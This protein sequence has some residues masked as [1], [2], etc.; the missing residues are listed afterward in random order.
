[1]RYSIV[2]ALCCL[3]VA[4]G[5]VHA[6]SDRGTITGTIT[7][8]AGAV[9]PNATIEAKNSETGAV[10]RAGSTETGN[11]TLSQLPAGVYQLSSS[12]SGFKQY[13]RTGITV[14]VAQTLRLDIVLEVGSIAETVTV[15]ADAPLLRTESGELSHNVTEARLD[16]LPILGFTGI[17]RDPYAVMTLLPGTLYQNR[18]WFRVNGAPSATMS[19]R[20]EGMEATNGM[21]AQSTGMSQQSMSAIEEYA[22][23]TSNYA[24]EFGQAGGGYF[25]ITMKSGTN[26]Y[27]GSA[28]D[29]LS[30]EAFNAAQPFVNIKTRLRRNDYGF[31]FGGPVFIP[32]VY[33]GH[34]KTFFFFN[35][36]QYR[37]H[38]LYNQTA[39]TMPTLA[40]RSGDFRQALTGRKLGTD[41]LGRDIMENTIYDPNTERLVNGQRVR[42]PFLNNT[43][44]SDRFD[45]VAVKIQNYIPLPQGPN[46]NSIT[47]N[48]L[49][50]WDS[51]NI[52]WIPGFKI[53]HNISAR[54][55]LAFFWSATHIHQVQAPGPPGGDG[56][57][58][59]ATTSRQTIQDS[60]IAHLSF[61]QTLTPTMV[62][63]LGTGL[64]NL[65]F[66]DPA[67]DTNFDQLKNLGL[68]GSMYNVFPF[69]SGLSAARGGM[70]ARS[71]GMPTGNMGPFMQT[72]SVMF[73]PAANA[74][75]TWV[76]QNHTYK[77]GGEARW[78]K[79]PSILYYPSYGGYN[80]SADQ[81]GLPST[82]GQ[83]LSGGTVG[84][85]Y[86]SFL[87]GL[88]A[89]GNTGVPSAPRLAK[90]AWSVFAQDTW[91]ITRRFTLDYGLR[92]D[93][94]DY[95]RDMQGRVA[96][97]SP[98][99]PN[100]SAGGLLGA[101]IYEGSGAGHCNCDFARVYPYAFGPRLGA[102]YQITP[103]TVLRI[104][105]GISYGQTAYESQTSW[106]VGANNPYYS[107]AYGNPAGLL[108]NGMPT[109]PSWPIY[110]A[111]LYPLPGTLSAPPVAIDRN[112]G[113]PPRQLQWSIG[114]QREIFANLVVEA[115]YVGNRGAW[116]E[117]NDLIN[118]NALT[119][120]RIASFG[121]DVNNAAD[122]ALLTSA[123]NSPL[124][125][126]RGFNKLPYA[127]FPM[128]ATVAQS[129]RPFPQFAGSANNVPAIAYIWAPLGRTWY[130]SL[131]VKVTKRF[132]H[133]LDFT[134]VFTWQKELTMGAEQVGNASGLSGA[135]VNDVFNR[136]MNKYL[137][138]LS[139]PFVSVTALNY[140]LPKL[141][142]N[143]ALSAA[144]QDWTFG[145]SLQY[146]SGL[147]VKA[148]TAQNSLS[149]VL[150]RD[151]FANRV[152]GQPLYT[153]DPNCYCVDPTVDFILNPNAW[154][155]PPA[156]QFGTGAA[157]YNDYRQQRRPGESMSLG[158]TFRFREGVTLN[159]RA[160]FQNVFN[161]TEMA[162]PTSTNAKATQTRAANGTTV[163][164]FGYI[165]SRSVA[166]APRAGMIVATFKF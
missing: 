107:P 13:V 123:L 32:G 130:D 73:K 90:S 2:I 111:G 45:P 6:Q 41:P 15:N 118:V 155:D 43:I 4:V 115:S 16:N 39:Y 55:K 149:P 78:E 81:T 96:S 112:A 10:Y 67:I 42:D 72:H 144:I 65:T 47:N 164:G 127:G 53:D 54:S 162:T 160:D 152:E 125:T 68:A 48:Y 9:I 139:R 11:Y 1:M 8:P 91:K 58:T 101:V 64:Q 30:N 93:Y 19:V 141:N 148:P 27:H 92:W 133:G 44:P 21:L 69:I 124:A 14:M 57:P 150:F 159:I 35:L 140:T 34:D 36:E 128:T 51:P 161:R 102:A 31:T 126:Q 103:K 80:F 29:Y 7:D 156:G 95:F 5:A 117:A 157:Y 84:F 60:Y 83:N 116:W 110:S 154:V 98:T 79:F 50:T 40:Y 137:S 82:L 131:Q 122:R 85:P 12:V 18:A 56:L 94:Q 100:P 114:I 89:D 146:A 158:R 3:V 66:Q 143:R 37:E 166:A 108:R 99:T 74:S 138:M 77:F 52:R 20:V 106:K 61:D 121:L 59:Q 63:H 62:L 86:A 134:S 97:F 135:S 75:L 119:A 26:A 76:K 145:A 28:Y 70:S 17:I 33:N 88:V 49:H 153:K 38:T 151:T 142:I 87:L 136:P 25:N 129:L 104:G 24:A 165:N 132:S 71:V 109:P 46:M 105:L 120:Q 22:I 23:Q 147:P 163:S 113:R